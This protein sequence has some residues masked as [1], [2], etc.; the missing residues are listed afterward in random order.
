MFLS[1]SLPCFIVGIFLY[2]Q[3]FFLTRRE[4]SLKSSC[5]SIQQLY[6]SISRPNK[7][8]IDAC[9]A[10]QR[11]DK[12]IFFIIDGLRL[13]YLVPSPK[14]L[15]MKDN[16]AY[17]HQLLH[18]NASQAILFGFRADPPT[19][20]SQR[21][22]ALTTGSLPTFLDFGLNFNH[23]LNVQDDNIIDQLI[24]NRERRNVTSKAI[25]LGDDTWIAL[26]PHRFDV[27]QPSDSFNTKD[28]YTVDNN[29]EKDLIPMLI[30]EEYDLLVAHFLGVDHVGH[31]YDAFHPFMN[32]RLQRM[33]GLINQTIATLDDETLLVIFGDHG[34]SDDGNHGGASDEEVNSAIIFYSKQNIQP[35]N[36]E[37]QALYWNEQTRKIDHASI[38]DLIARPRIVSQID[39]VP[40]LSLLLGNPIPYSNLGHIILELFLDNDDLEHNKLKEVLD[41][42]AL[43]VSKRNL[44]LFSVF[45]TPYTVFYR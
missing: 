26:Y 28:L 19:T 30:Q 39:L 35:L 34:M 27:A 32:E 5:E 24:A 29:I 42:N 9:T 14:T 44:P 41:I 25:F 13:D 7:P 21:L 36:D 40:T 43:Q 22:K 31:T 8:P 11:F 6:D 3:G 2:F 4:L 38:A 33:D 18:E 16:F 1:I 20:T 15:H 37:G 10:H 23:D 17:M 12:V 45:L